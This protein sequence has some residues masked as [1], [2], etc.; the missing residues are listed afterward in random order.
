[1]TSNARAPARTST[2]GALRSELVAFAR[3]RTGD[4]ALAEDIVQRALLA[5]VERRVAGRNIVPVRDERAWLFHAVRNAIVD[6]ARRAAVRA[7]PL[8]IV[9]ADVRIDEEPAITPAAARCARSLVHA[10]PD[11]YADAVRAVD[12]DDAEARALL[13]ARG[14]SRNLV[15]QRAVRG[16]KRLKALLKEACGIERPDDDC[17]RS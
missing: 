10:L 7:R 2:P 8:A 13:D 1:V 3:A 6:E 14:V 9:D 12:L 11:D 15:A 17:R 16:R 5:S 4:A